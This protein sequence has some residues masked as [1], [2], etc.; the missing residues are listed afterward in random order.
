M[1]V[2]TSSGVVTT[3]YL[4]YGNTITNGS[5]QDLNA[6]NS[7]IVPI[8]NASRV[9]YG[10]AR[11]VNITG[12][13]WVFSN[14]SSMSDG[15]SVFTSASSGRVSLSG[16]LDRVRFLAGSSNSFDGGTVNIIYQ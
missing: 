4:S 1:Q 10:I 12:N 16:T 5:T 13:D 15:T 3:G 2:G 7:F 11:I 14:T 9:L 8:A 6:T